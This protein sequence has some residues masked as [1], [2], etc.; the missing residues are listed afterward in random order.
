MNTVANKVTVFR[1]LLIP[2]FLALAYTGHRYMAVVVFVV[3]CLSDLLDG[4]IARHYDQTSNFGRFMDPLADK[5]LTVSAMCYLV[6]VRQLSGLIV[7]IILFR[8]FAVSGL[9]LMAIERQQVISARISGK[10]KTVFTMIALAFML[11]FPDLD[12]VNIIGSYG[13]LAV[14]V[15]SGIDY[16]CA[17]RH[18][19][20]ELNKN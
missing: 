1:I 13:I 20:S 3:A 6:D 8:E 11:H 5:M 17:N 18:I 9:R 19:I 14:T 10:I 15:L 12:V 2:V 16:F 7:A 4:Y